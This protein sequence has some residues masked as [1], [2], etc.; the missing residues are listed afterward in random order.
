MEDLPANAPLWL[1]IRRT[2]AFALPIVVARSAILIM[3]TVD[4]MMTGWS[5]ARELA[6]LGLGMAPQLTLM[7]IAI[8]LL[9]STVVLTSQ[10]FGARE[11]ERCGEIWR[12]GLAHGLLL[13]VGI[14]ALSFLAEPFFLLTGQDPGIAAG[15]ARVTQVFALSVPG[16]L[17]YVTTN[18]F[19][20]ATGRQRVGMTVMLVAN[21]LNIPLN[22]VFAL[23]WGGFTEPL[24]AVGAM[25]TSAALRWLSFLAVLGYA[26]WAARRDDRFGVRASLAVWARALATLGGPIGKAMRRLGLPIGLAQGVES[27]AFA[28]VVLIAGHLGE[29]ALVAH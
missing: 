2:F 4:T 28:T 19:L 18:L 22:G 16:M 12:A 23:G 21:L 5:G 27:A 29:K 26:L 13:G 6:Y 25:G 10:A 8:G 14:F 9:T 1:Q 11:Y 15:A 17:L 3:F 20:E 7:L 24:G